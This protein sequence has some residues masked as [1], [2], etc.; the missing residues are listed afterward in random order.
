MKITFENNNSKYQAENLVTIEEIYDAIKA[1]IT[2]M[3][4]HI[5]T[6]N[7]LVEELKKGDDE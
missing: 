3:T 1:E 6:A 7:E 2:A 4:F 5:N